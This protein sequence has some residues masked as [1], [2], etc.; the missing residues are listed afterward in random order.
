MT[1]ELI[2]SAE[3]SYKDQI[4]QFVS[5]RDDLE[6]TPYE[7]IEMFWPHPLLKVIRKNK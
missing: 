2:D 6:K 4:N 7:K 3:K 1:H 5:M